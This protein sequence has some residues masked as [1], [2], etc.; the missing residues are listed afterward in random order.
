MI[1]SPTLLL[2]IGKWLA[3]GLAIFFIS[4]QIYKAGQNSIL[5]K[6]QSFIINEVQKD[7]KV[8]NNVMRLDDVA[9]RDLLQSHY[10][11]TVKR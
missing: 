7:E 9:K 3:I 4:A 5:V 8:Y 1:F 11:R 10:A 6:Q 2:G